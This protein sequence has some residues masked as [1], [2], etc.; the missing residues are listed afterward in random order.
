MEQAG[1]GRRFAAVMVDWI[2]AVATTNLFIQSLSVGTAVTRQAV[3]FAE[4]AIMTY[5]TQSSI[6]QRIFLIK[7]V[8]NQTGD[9]L[10]P[11]RI[12]KR[13]LLLALFIPAIFTQGGRGYHDIL[14][15][16]VVI[17]FKRR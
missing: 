8:D 4:I 16:S 11:L 12:F 7:V 6:G 13:T 5:L 15:G 9:R 10:P 2:L 3:F 17:E 1:F 14:S